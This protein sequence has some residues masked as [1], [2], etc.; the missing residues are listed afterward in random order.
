MS[1]ALLSP[2]QSTSA[3]TT[4]DEEPVV[5]F[6]RVSLSFDDT[7][8]LRDLSFTLPRGRM[9]MLVGAS[10]A[11]KSI[12]LKLILGLLRPDEGGVFVNGVRVDELQEDALAEIRSDIGIT[13][14]ELALF[15]SLTVEENVGY[16]LDEELHWPMDRVRQRVEEVLGFVGLSAEIQRMPS[17]LSGGQRRR[18]AIARAMASNPRLLLFDDPTT[19]LDPLIATSVDNEIV[20]LRDLQQVTSL[21]VTHQMRD[22][23]YIAHHRAVPTQEGAEIV[24]SDR[25]QASEV[26][27]MV[28]HGGTISFEGTA[29]ELLASDDP[30]LKEFMHK[31]LPPW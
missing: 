19:G 29:D 10:G 20:R 11:G 14:Q 5:R 27:F 9:K 31:T 2:E 12:V 15:D 7:H 22:A 21:M 8:V 6:D 3:P 18:V 28:L 23:F 26:R 4:D 25:A 16:R 13:F 24:R 17:S 30:Q 1:H